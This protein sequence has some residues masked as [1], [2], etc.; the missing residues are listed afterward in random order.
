MLGLICAKADLTYQRGMPRMFS[1]RTRYDYYWPAFAHLG[2]Q[3]VLN[4]EIYYQGNGA[5]GDD[6]VFGYQERYA[7]YRYK[8]SQITG[9]LRSSFAQTL[10]SWHLA[11]SF[12]S[13]PGL[14]QTFIE[15]NPPITRVVAVTSSPQ[16]IFDA[17]IDLKCARA[18][19]TYGVPGMMDHF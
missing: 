5:S 19:P 9:A 8:P 15:E 13:T 4:K 10:D 2:E 17:W 18:M 14:N 1:R 12:G 6:L 16:F 3:T 7:E 11:Q